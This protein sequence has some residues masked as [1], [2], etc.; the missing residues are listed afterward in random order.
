MFSRLATALMALLAP[1]VMLLMVAQ[2]QTSVPAPSGNPSADEIVARME[3][4]NEER[5]LAQPA[6]ACERTYILNYHGFPESKHAEMNVRSLQ[7]GA[8]K[9]FTILNESGSGALRSRVLHKMLD[10]EREASVG[11]LREDSRLTRRNYD[12]SLASVAAT[13]DGPLY[14]LAIKP[15]VKSKVAWSGRIWVDARDYAV[16]RAEG[17]PDKMPSWWTTHSD[18][19]STYQK[20]DGAWLPRQNISE[21]SVRFGGHAHLE[22]T[23]RNCSTT[24]REYS[25]PATP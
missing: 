25:S 4:M 8:R 2:A 1:A 16:V 12:F 15:K 18:F 24:S 10:T 23:Y 17:Q 13:P 21:T 7:V 9:E 14:V 20:V 6:F 22:I 11:T 5:V 3:A 19:V